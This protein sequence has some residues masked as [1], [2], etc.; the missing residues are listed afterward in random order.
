MGNPRPIRLCLVEYRGKRVI[1]SLR[2]IELRQ[3][4]DHLA[5]SRTTILRKLR[6]TSPGNV[7]VAYY[8]S[9]IRNG[10]KGV[11]LPYWMLL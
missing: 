10:Y 11:G 6:M 9:E 5:T 8:Y 2:R 4:S 3:H 7:A 1:L